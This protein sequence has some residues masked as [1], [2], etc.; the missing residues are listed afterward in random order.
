MLRVNALQ[1]RAQT[2]GPVFGADISFHEGLNVVRA[3]NSSGKSTCL[4][5]LLYSLGLEGMLSPRR[6]V[7]LP[8]A[9]TDSIELAGK[10]LNVTR[11]LV[12]LEIQNG[13]GEVATVE[14]SV[15][16]REPSNGLVK[17]LSGK[18]LTG[19]GSGQRRDYFVRRRGAAQ[20]E[21]GFHRWLADFLGWELPRVARTDGSEGLL[22]LECL[23]PYFFVEQKHGWL[24]LQA[25]IPTYFGIRDVVRRSAEFVL[26]LDAY[27]LVLQRQRLESEGANVEV[28]WRRHLERVQTSAA[29]ASVV[30]RGLGV[31][32]PL[33]PD[34]ATFDL[35]MP[36]GSQWIDLDEGIRRLRAEVAEASSLP[37][38]TVAA[39]EEGL[40]E[41]L[42]SAQTELTVLTAALS[43]ALGNYDESQRR[44][45]GLDVRLAALEEDLQRHKDAAVLRSLGSRNTQVVFGAE[46]HCPT[47]HQFL[48]DGFDVTESPMSD[49]QNIAFIE[50]ELRSFRAMHQ[51]ALRLTGALKV[52]V[53]A[54]RDA[55]AAT[56][57]Q[58]RAIKDSLVAP[59]SMPSPAD[60]AAQIH[61]ET[62]LQ[63]LEKF[64]D[65]MEG[66]E[67]ALRQVAARWSTN[68][69]LLAELGKDRLSAAD[70]AKIDALG[71]SFRSQLTRYGFR[72]LSPAD[73][74]ISEETYRPT[75]DG[76]D[77][78][79]DLSASD[80]IRSIWAYLLSLAE[81]GRTYPTNHLGFLALDEPRQQEVEYP[82][83]ASFVR[84]LAEVSGPG[85]QILV[86]TSEEDSRMREMLTGRPHN[87]ISIP[88][89]EKLLKPVDE[90]YV[91]W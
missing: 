21:A 65:E 75:H 55:S 84:R 41:R 9:M 89:R 30:P 36:A 31:R 77:L 28:E 70:R 74:R 39:D 78:G 59:S 62:Q 86:A 37:L 57:A 11:S 58:V 69:R 45:N 90:D 53:Q 82:D 80:M 49:E 87:L 24:G 40:E 12:R 26:S 56:R 51:D 16:G 7:P 85:L 8:H 22:Y 43:E 60:I 73:I 50:Q 61:L 17:V 13:R 38:Q 81:L 25:R 34:L 27:N 10:R 91:E 72:S 5:A 44:V 1:L 2:S 48:P 4:Q 46:P 15:K 54:L 32:P 47:C 23:F 6:E 68:R 35:L 33:D 42:E 79:F 3:D 71:S 52:R 64:R 67:D 88:P 76:F 63:V 29:S 14:R 83:F 20:N 66:V 18:G 19:D